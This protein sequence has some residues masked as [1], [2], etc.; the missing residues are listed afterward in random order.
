M[1][2]GAQHKGFTVNRTTPYTETPLLD[3]TGVYSKVLFKSVTN[4]LKSVIATSNE[5][6]RQYNNKYNNN[7][8]NVINK[9]LTTSAEEGHER[10]AF[11]F[12]STETAKEWVSLDFSTTAETK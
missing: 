1:P 11:E 4:I 6:T 5:A 10:A 12:T 7:N 2:F 3:A 9:I 8:N